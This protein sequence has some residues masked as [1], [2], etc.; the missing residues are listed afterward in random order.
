MKIAISAEST[1]DL[2]KQL[3]EQFDIHT[4]PFS[5]ILGEEAKLDGEVSKYY[6]IM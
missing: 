3:L 4:V 1:V 6:L 5:V 2:T